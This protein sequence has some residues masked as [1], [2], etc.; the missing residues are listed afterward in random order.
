MNG[1]RIKVTLSE[2]Q[3]MFPEPGTKLA[4]LA[5]ARDTAVQ[6]N[7]RSLSQSGLLHVRE[8]RDGI[9]IESTS[10]VGR[11]SLDPLEISIKPKITGAPLLH[12][13]RYT[14]GLRNLKLMSYA[15]YAT[16]P[17]TFQDLLVNQLAAEARELISR[18]LHRKYVGVS[19]DLSSPTGR[20]DVQRMARLGG[21]Y[22][23]TLPC[24]HFPRLENHLVNQ[25]LLEGLRLAARV[26]SVVPLK[27]DLRCIMKVIEGGVSTIN[28]NRDTMRRLDRAM[29]RLTTAYRPVTNIIRML[30]ESEGISLEVEGN[31]VK[32]DGFLFDMNRFFQALISRFLRNNLS[33]YV[34]HD[35]HRLKGM[36]SYVA[37]YNHGRRHSPEPRPDFVVMKGT[38][39]VSILDA[40]YRDLSEKSLPSDM[41]YQL[42]IYALSH[43]AQ[44]RATILYPTTDEYAAED[45]IEIRDT[46][47]GEGRALVILRPLNLVRL[48]DL[49]SGHDSVAAQRA[50]ITYARELAFGK[51]NCAATE[52][53]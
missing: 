14:Y 47:S 8:L 48:H 13:M 51:Y 4:D 21:A 11:V 32:L 46:V 49:T 18:G 53:I 33:E 36:M 12:L 2:W 19:E 9:A 52:R 45:R 42:A 39:I 27:T 15:G 34:V 5:F 26:T 16:E 22:R 31:Q 20:I 25:V 40:K 50:R 30:V 1:Q 43:H 6:R 28:L 35:E 29:D 44:G 10:Y 23:A 38:Q 7:L 24:M 41:L 37:G 17:D 3:S